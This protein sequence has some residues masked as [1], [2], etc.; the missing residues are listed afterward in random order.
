MIELLKSINTLLTGDTTLMAL[1]T[2]GAHQAMA[3]AKTVP[4]F[5]IFY[6]VPAAGP[7]YVFGGAEA[8]DD[9]LLA[10]KGVA[11]DKDDGSA[12]GVDLAEQIRERGKVLLSN[13]S[14]S[15]TGFNVLS[16]LCGQPLPAM[17]ENVGGR[18]R[19][20]RGDYY[21]ALLQKV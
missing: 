10:L 8:Y 14:L 20:H 1:A 5:V 2:S 19:Y 15:V 6:I 9:I 11:Q 7:A 21:R 13:A 18:I 16:V 12:A 4:P 17:E 3:P